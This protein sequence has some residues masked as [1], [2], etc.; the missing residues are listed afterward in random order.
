MELNV[1]SNAVSDLLESDIV[2]VGVVE[3]LPD[4]LGDASVLVIEILFLEDFVLEVGVLAVGFLD[5][6]GSA[7]FQVVEFV[8]LYF[9]TFLETGDVTLLGFTDNLVLLQ[10]AFFERIDVL[11]FAVVEESVALLPCS[12]HHLAL[13]N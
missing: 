4:Q 6:N 2:V 7:A 13:L 11:C 3:L 9:S 5:H 10:I 8:E 1:L 12:F